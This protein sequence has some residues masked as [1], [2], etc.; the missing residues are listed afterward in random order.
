MNTFQR[1]SQF[2]KTKGR[3]LDGEKVGSNIR[4]GIP[5]ITNSLRTSQWLATALLIEGGDYKL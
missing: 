5:N 4:H 2:G 1:N 3:I